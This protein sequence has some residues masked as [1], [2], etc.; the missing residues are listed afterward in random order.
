MIKN[1]IRAL[2]SLKLSI[3]LLVLA[4]LLV[5]F[6][7]WAQVDAG[8]YEVQKRYFHSWFTWASF[9]TILP[10]TSEGQL[11]VPGGF[12]MPGGYA[13]GLLM[14]LNLLASWYE[15]LVWKWNKIGLHLVH[16]GLVVLLLGEAWTSVAQIDSR[17]TIKQGDTVAYTEDSRRI[18]LALMDRST[19]DRDQ[20]WSIRQDLLRTGSVISEPSMPVVL[21]VDEFAPNSQLLGP[22]QAGTAANAKATAGA[23]VGVTML[24]QRKGGSTSDSA[25]APSMYV[26]VLEKGQS[27]GTYLLSFYLPLDQA[28][29]VKLGD[30]KSLYLQLRPKRYS[31][32][33]EIKLVEFRNDRYPGTNMARNYSSR[34]RLVD[35]AQNVDRE[36]VIW[37]N[38]PLR[39]GGQTFYQSGYLGEDTTILQVVRNPAMLMPYVAC[40]IGTI[41]MVLQFSIVLWGF[42]AT[43]GA[44]SPSA[45]SG[46]REVEPAGWAGVAVPVVVGLFCAF[47]LLAQYKASQVS[48]D[49]IAQ[50]PVY[51]EG[52]LQPLDSVARNALRA[53]AGRD[54]TVDVS[55]AT[56]TSLQW[57]L[58]ALCR[59]EQALKYPILRIDNPQVQAI[60]NLDTKQKRFSLDDLR[61]KMDELERQA[62]RA[63]DT[64]SGRRD[65]VDRKILELYQKISLYTEVSQ[66]SELYLL[67][68]AVGQNTWRPLG[69]VMNQATQN[70]AKIEPLAQTISGALGDYHVKPSLEPT[71]SVRQWISTLDQQ[72]PADMAKMHL[73]V[74]Y[75]RYQP[76]LQAMVLYIIAFL[77]A[78]VSMLVWQRPLWRSA[79]VVMILAFVVQTLA[80]WT[81]IYLMGRPPVTNLYSSAVFI[82]W[83]AVLLAMFFEY[84]FRNGIV[85]GMAS[86]VG[87][88]TLVIA[89]NLAQGGDTMA[90]LQ[91]VLDSNFWLTTH[92]LAITYGY[93][94]VFVAGGLGIAYVL[95]NLFSAGFAEGGGKTIGRMIYGIACFAL[96]FSFVGTI[97]GGI[98]ADQSWGRFWGWDPKENGAV[99][100]VIWVAIMLHA[101]WVGGGDR[102]MA[103][104]AIFGNIVTAWSWFGTNMLGVGLHSYG[105][106][107]Q[108]L[109]WLLVFVG[110]QLLLIL[111]GWLPI[112]I[113]TQKPQIVQVSAR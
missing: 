61:P 32:P 75:N 104:M 10:R 13:I 59:P 94:A 65:T 87:T 112:R 80:I 30:G 68:P 37:M 81:R 5:Y 113:S 99:L 89:Q 102:A 28:Q 56:I 96:L 8:I 25:D 45:R 15:R 4:L 73:E 62:H 47:Y 16:L 19:P 78:C 54:E 9:G 24:A 12:P 52:R 2:A 31:L 88:A 50:A 6:G 7:T 18:E 49:D 107:D 69:E 71:D 64:P 11:A 53:T 110:T 93:S 72:R 77:L 109:M 35:R 97:L 83:G 84:F 86:L 103:L 20:V 41:G 70:G 26:T 42:A 108:A 101:R 79:M 33:Y 51:F 27:R 90:S 58:D 91:A 21:Q 57:L 92:V 39:H 29:E 48:A 76:F 43:R 67:P 55:G 60:L 82:G 22:A 66:W 95:G 44:R 98:W 38:H 111:L 40:I 106:M 63:S 85:M 105:F 46:K 1:A 23:G 17:M 34:I 3:V 100:I 74:F 36:E 14:L